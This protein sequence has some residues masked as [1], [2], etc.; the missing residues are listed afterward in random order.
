MASALK[1]TKSLAIYYA[2]IILA[3]VFFSV[4]SHAEN[5]PRAV[6]IELV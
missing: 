4:N 3:D 5:M 1:L 6:S 2:D